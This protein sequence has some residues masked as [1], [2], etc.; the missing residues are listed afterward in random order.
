VCL[1]LDSGNHLVYSSGACGTGAGSSVDSVTTGIAAAGT[2]QGTATTIS[3]QQ[4]YVATGAN[5][6]SFP[7]CSGSAGVILN[8]SLLA[9]GTHVYVTNEDATNALVLYPPSGDTI[10]LLAANTPIYIQANQTAHLI[11]KS[12]SALRTVP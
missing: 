3:S 6:A 2:T 11:S 1:G 12:A 7:T 8:G 10:N 9:A 4:N 5:C